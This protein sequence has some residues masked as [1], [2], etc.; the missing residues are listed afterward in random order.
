MKF[1]IDMN[2]S[3][4][5]VELF[6]AAGFEAIHWSKIGPQDASDLE[7][8]TSAAANDHIVVTCDLDFTA[9]L[10]AS[11]GTRPS[12][13]Q[14]RSDILNAGADR[15]VRAHCGPAGAAGTSGRRSSLARYRSGTIAN[16]AAAS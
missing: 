3:P 15:S 11:R 9:I 5:W 16:P 8:M 10:A 12:V 1:L 14:L 2:L 13:L 4:A 6:A 7:L